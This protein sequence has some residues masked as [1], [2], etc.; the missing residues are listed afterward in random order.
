MCVPYRNL[1]NYIGPINI[2]IQS[3][4]QFQLQRLVTVIHT[5][6]LPLLTKA[7]LVFRMFYSVCVCVLVGGG[8]GCSNRNLV[9]TFFVVILSMKRGGVDAMIIFAQ[10]SLEITQRNACTYYTYNIDSWYYSQLLVFCG[11]IVYGHQLIIGLSPSGG[12]AIV[13]VKF[14]KFNL[15]D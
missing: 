11:S 3:V 15:Y 14:I 12:S 8:R 7:S 4:L 2:H 6:P 9:S 1:S 13:I 10:S 5:S